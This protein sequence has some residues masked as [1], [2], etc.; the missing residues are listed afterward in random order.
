MPLDRID[1]AILKALASD[2]RVSWR[3]LAERVNLSLTPV[4]KRVQRLERDGFITGY[5]ARIDEARLG[6]AI[7]VFVSV[8]LEKQVE[9]VLAV[10]E[11]HILRAPEVM[12]CHLMT[13]TADYLLRVIVHDLDAYQAFLVGTL[14]R[15]PGVANIQSSFA[16]KSV[17][18]RYAPPL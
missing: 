15:I 14:T 4:L 17:V 12:S 2:G 16:L 13:G 5:S 9:N 8:Q 11:Q 3:E 18:Q 7:C 1:R 6:G 10:F